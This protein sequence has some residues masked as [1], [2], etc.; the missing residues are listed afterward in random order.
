MCIRDRNHRGAPSQNTR[1]STPANAPAHTMTSRLR[2]FGQSSSSTAS[3]VYD[4]AM[5]R[6]MLVWSSRRSAAVTLGDQRPRW[7]PRVTAAL[8]RL[9][10][11]N[12]FPVSYTH[13]RAHETDS[14]LVCR[15]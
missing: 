14:Y 12:I 15:L 9:D 2:L 1:A 7:S 13:L 11:T 6:K 3:G 5:I 8:R 10:H 4:P